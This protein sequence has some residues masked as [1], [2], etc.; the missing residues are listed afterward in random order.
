MAGYGQ[1]CP[2][3]KA[4][5]LL[6]ERWTVLVLRELLAGSTHFN[7]LRRGLPHMSP[8]L[9]SKRLR[10]LTRA[11]LLVRRAD[12]GEVRYELTEAGRELG[13]IVQALGGW[14]VRWMPDLGDLDLDPHLLMWDLHRNIDLAAV[15]PGRTVIHVAFTDVTHSARW[16]VVV[17]DGAV[18]L[19]DFDPGHGVSVTLT[20]DLRTMVLIWRG[21][22]P[23]PEA[24][25]DGRLTITG[26][27]QARRGVLRWLTLSP[28]AAVARP[29]APAPTV[30]VPEPA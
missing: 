10:T 25:R 13:P 5:E 27:S 23:W 3:A 15:P 29:P 26:P 21:D 12:H 8:A 4:M 9:L 22:V 20:T 17:E 16:W 1:F 2:I 7:Q 11:G 6:D 19:C 18:D 14:A 24:M 28:F 30:R